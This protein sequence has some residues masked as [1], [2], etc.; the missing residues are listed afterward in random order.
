M[1]LLRGII[2]GYE[3]APGKGVPIGNLTSQF[4]ANLYLAGLDRFIL[5]KL[6][7]LAYCRY[8]D[9]FVLWGRLRGRSK[10]WNNNAVN[11]RSANR[12]NNTPSNRNNNLGFRL[13]R[14]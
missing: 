4:F 3:T 14:P 11:L 10:P 2:D 13:V 1:A 8:M 9:D 7:P 6:H 5:E 12:N